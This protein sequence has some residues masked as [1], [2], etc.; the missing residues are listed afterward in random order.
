MTKEP[1]S[2]RAL[3][4]LAI[5]PRPLDDYRKMFLI[6]DAEL[7]AGPILDCPAGASPF[8]AQVRALGGTVISVDRAYSTSPAEIVARARADVV[9]IAKWATDYPD[10]FDWSYLGS[11]D[12]LVGK[13]EVAIEEFAADYL[14]DG[15]RYVTAALPDLPF[16][17]D[18]FHLALSSHLLFVYP[19]YF[20]FDS[21]VTALLELIRVTRAEVRVFPL[22][23]TATRPYS[24]LDEL[25][26][27]L[28]ERGVDTEI[29]A[30]RCAY[31]VGGDHLLACW[32]HPDG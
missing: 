29:R 7:T 30:A 3:G 18:Y 1:N 21:H 25:R 2:T 26:S 14:A 15:E 10:Q 27:V 32:R 11:V 5:T 4:Q 22:V 8:G 23:D 19:E 20:D 16:P 17:D 9:R 31:S 6:T 13:W 24:R 28:A 12:A